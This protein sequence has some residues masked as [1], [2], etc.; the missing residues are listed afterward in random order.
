MV[1]WRNQGLPLGSDHENTLRAVR[2]ARGLTAAKLGKLAGTATSSVIEVELGYAS[3]LD[4]DGQV[5]RWVEKALLI[6]EEEFED[7]FPRHRC[8]W[9]VNAKVELVPLNE[10]LNIPAMEPPFGLGRF[11]VQDAIKEAM[12]D[13]RPREQ[14]VL[15]LRFG[16][17]FTLDD[18]G[19]WL[20]VNRER[21]RQIE[22][23]ALRKPSN[24]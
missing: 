13:L 8:K 5:R 11:E 19:A 24:G 12:S 23:M 10:A 14:T 17:D 18:V 16:E 15:A 4:K 20:G 2:R 21:A 7:V 22:A 9:V 1:S 6:L 3:P